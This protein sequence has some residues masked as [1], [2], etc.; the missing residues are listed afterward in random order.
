MN[1]LVPRCAGRDEL[2]L[3][4]GMAQLAGTLAWRWCS[5]SSSGNQITYRDQRLRGPR[6]AWRGL[7]LFLVVCGIGAAA[8]A[9][10][11]RGCCTQAHHPIG[12]WRVGSGR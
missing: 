12:R 6:L 8:N 2:G 10:A 4:F 9:W 11:S 3:S 7:L 1:L 5:T